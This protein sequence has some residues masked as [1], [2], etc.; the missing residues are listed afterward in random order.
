VLWEKHE[1]S[2]FSPGFEAIWDSCFTV[3]ITYSDGK[4]EQ[5]GISVFL[6]AFVTPG[7]DD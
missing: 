7:G 6:L 1:L 2:R 3:G 4:T 5:N